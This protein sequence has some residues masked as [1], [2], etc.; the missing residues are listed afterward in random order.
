MNFS[1]RT[2]TDPDLGSDEGLT[3]HTLATETFTAKL[4][5][6]CD[7]NRVYSNDH[8]RAAELYQRAAFDTALEIG[9]E[10]VQEDIPGGLQF[11]FNFVPTITITE[12]EGY[13]PAADVAAAINPE[14]DWDLDAVTLEELEGA[15]DQSDAEIC[16]TI[17]GAIAD[18]DKLTPAEQE[19]AQRQA[20]I[21]AERAAF[22]AEHDASSQRFDRYTPGNGLYFCA[23]DGVETPDVN[24]CDRCKDIATARTHWKTPAEIEAETPVL[25]AVDQGNGL[26]GLKKD[27]VLVMADESYTVVHGIVEGAPVGE[28][29]EIGDELRGFAA[30]DPTPKEVT[31][32][33]LVADD[34][35]ALR[36]GLA[37]VHLL[38]LEANQDQLDAGLRRFDTVHGDKTV[39]GLA[40]TIARVFDDADYLQ[41]LVLEQAVDDE[42]LTEDQLIGDIHVYEDDYEIE[43]EFTDGLEDYRGGALL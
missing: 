10:L 11:T 9:V 21:R 17:R 27:G 37:L 16:E 2:A 43:E 19:E 38:G 31:G 18:W 34:F 41:E 39:Q 23:C 24:W 26:W 32:T 20:S 30:D 42:G 1:I 35:G 29:Q 33:A 36:V 13:D 6:L 4:N 25:E 7:A 15:D 3:Q 8:E 5:A 22:T 28:L 14:E 40:R 12:V